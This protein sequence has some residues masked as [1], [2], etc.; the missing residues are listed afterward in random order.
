MPQEQAGFRKGRGTRDHI[1]NLRW[2][3]EKAREMQKDIFMCFIDYSKAF[4]CVDHDLL[5]KI[6]QELGIPRHLIKLMNNLYTNQETTMRTEF[7]NTLWFK[8]GKGVRQGCVL[9]PYLF[10]LYTENIMRKAGI[11]KIQGI[12][13]KGRMINNLRY[14]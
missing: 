8:I 5:W 4:D 3:M 1:A 14:S 9:S 6:L 2:I 10:N 7:G 13:I 12:K 11:E